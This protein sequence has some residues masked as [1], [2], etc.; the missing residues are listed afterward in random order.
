MDMLNKELNTKFGAANSKIF[1]HK[2][3]RL[4]D[5][6]E[7]F[8]F[9]LQNNPLVSVNDTN[10]GRNKVPLSKTICNLV[11]M[12]EINQKIEVKDSDTSQIISSS[13]AYGQDI[14]SFSTEQEILNCHEVTSIKKR[15][16]EPIFEINLCSSASE[17][18]EEA[19]VLT[20]SNNA[21]VNYKKHIKY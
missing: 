6:A 21:Q 1:S 20:P 5:N 13:S 10:I 2:A 15:V 18:E 11:D 4:K 8:T 16:N 14:K 3:S 12:I 19:V 9:L 7:K 17:N